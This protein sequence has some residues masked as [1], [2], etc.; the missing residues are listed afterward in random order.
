LKIQPGYIVQDNNLLACSVKHIETVFEMLK[1][2]PK[3]IEF[4]GGLDI[5]YLKPWHVELFKKIKVAELWVACDCKEDLPR[6]DKAVDLLSDYSIEKKRCYVLVGKD[7]ETQ[8]QAQERCVAVYRKGFLPFAQL[9]RGETAGPSRGEWHD[10][11]HLW[12]KPGLYRKL[13]KQGCDNVCNH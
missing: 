4:K 11:C 3:P 13:F 2:Q 7:G 6:L 8:A 9:Y 10:L 12:A 1:L 5:D